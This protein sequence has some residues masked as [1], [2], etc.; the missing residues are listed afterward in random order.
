MGCSEG[1]VEL[2]QNSWCPAALR[3]YSRHWNSFSRWCREKRLDSGSVEPVRGFFLIEWFH[4]GFGSLYYKGTVGSF[5][6]IQKPT[7]E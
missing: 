2:T 5:E 7:L 1:V 3:L 6:G 4:I